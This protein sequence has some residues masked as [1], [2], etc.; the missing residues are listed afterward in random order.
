MKNLVILILSVSLVIGVVLAGGCRSQE[1]T[2]PVIEDVSPQEALA[3]I[4]ENQDSPDFVILDVRTPEE[5]ADGHIENAINLDFRSPDFPDEIG[6][7]DKNK[8]YLLYCRSGNRSGQALEI[9][10]ELNFQKIYHL[11]AGII[12]W[13]DEGLPLVTTP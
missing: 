12:G 8:T 5:Y 9:I 3:L 11:S 10:R 13:Q 1:T 6:K 4:Q 2:A 7:L